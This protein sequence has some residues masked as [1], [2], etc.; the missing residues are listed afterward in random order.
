MIHDNAG[1]G[2][3]QDILA[4]NRAFNMNY[5]SLPATVK[6]QDLNKTHR[7]SIATGVFEAQAL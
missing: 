6:D 4:N 5:T 7:S 2:N 1:G 3:R